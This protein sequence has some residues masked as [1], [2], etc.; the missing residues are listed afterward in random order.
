MTLLLTELTDH[1][2]GD[3]GQGIPASAIIRFH[4]DGETASKYSVISLEKNSPTSVIAKWKAQATDLCA[5]VEE[6][7]HVHVSDILYIG[8]CSGVVSL[9]TAT[10]I[11]ASVAVSTGAFSS[12]QRYVYTDVLL[13]MDPSIG[14]PVFTGSGLDDMS[15]NNPYTRAVSNDEFYSGAADGQYE[16]VIEHEAAPDK[17]KWRKDSGSWTEDVSIT[18][19]WQTIAEGVKVK[20]AATTGHTA[21]DKWIVPVGALIEV[22]EGAPFTVKPQLTIAEG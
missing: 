19:D 17:F 7:V 15:S 14:L 22:E 3:G 16:F 2:L 13:M 6:T 12:S 5:E 10:D 11:A 9:G 1:I 20:F 4:K 8:S 18:G 21:G